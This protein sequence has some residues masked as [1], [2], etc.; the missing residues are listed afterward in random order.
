MK[1]LQDLQ[2]K[3]LEKPTAP[4]MVKPGVNSLPE[5]KEPGLDTSPVDIQ[6]WL[7]LLTSPMSDLS[8]GS[9]GWWKEVLARAEAAYK[10][11]SQLTPLQKVSYVLPATKDLEEG[12][13]AGVNS[14]ASSMILAALAEGVKVE[15]VAKKVTGSS[16]GLI[17]RLLTLYRPGGENE[18]VMIL[19]QLQSPAKYVEAGKAA[20]GCVRGFDGYSEPTM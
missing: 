2:A 8:D 19:N 1:Q 10:A 13:F 7:E 16:A 15:C 5:L 20:E 18:K 9:S 11:W 14:R 17:F 6:D 12:R 3:A 4:E